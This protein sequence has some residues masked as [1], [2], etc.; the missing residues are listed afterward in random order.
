MQSH[1]V[2]GV[3]AMLAAVVSFSIMDVIMKRLVETYPSMQVTFLR[4]FASLPFLLA[5]T[6]LFGKWRELIPVHWKLH[7]LRGLISVV[8]L[9][10]FIYSVSILSLADAYT[11][12]MSAPLLITALSV[13]LL[14]DR[15]EWR[16]WIAVLAGMVGVMIVLRPTGAG[17][18]TLG[19]L[20]ALGAA[21]GYA[22]SAITIRILARTDSGAAT[23]LW[24]LLLMTIFSGLLAAPGWTALRTQ[25]W[26]W[27]FGLGLSGALG[28]YFITDAFRRAQPA[29]I[30]PLEYTALAWGMM[31]DWLI[32]NTSPSTR[33]LVGASIIVASGLYVIRRERMAE[34]T[35]EAKTDAVSRPS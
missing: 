13:L 5:A 21:L 35:V 19:G 8:T 24:A 1:S 31:F 14:H 10:S 32:W 28:Q 25:D 16:R 6:A 7:L 15:V 26:L 23:M 20:A 11:I 30:A 29:V 2:R 33:M 3:I 12:F 27:I 17:L 9:C 22:V 18:V 34:I 4:G